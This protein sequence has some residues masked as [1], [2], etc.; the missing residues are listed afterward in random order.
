MASHEKRITLH[1]FFINMSLTEIIGLVNDMHSCINQ[2]IDRF[3]PR[4]NHSS[5]EN[6]I[7][8]PAKLCFVVKQSIRD[9]AVGNVTLNAF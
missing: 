3:Q 8:N 7:S 4:S 1:I 9:A 2:I 6:I 5:P